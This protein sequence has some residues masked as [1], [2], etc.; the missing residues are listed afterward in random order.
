MFFQML[1]PI[2]QEL[3]PPMKTPDQRVQSLTVGVQIVSYLLTVSESP[4][5]HRCLF[6]LVMATIQRAPIIVSHPHNFIPY[7]K[8]TKETKGP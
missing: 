1:H 7:K 5:T 4:T 6:G 8:A 3:A 2:L